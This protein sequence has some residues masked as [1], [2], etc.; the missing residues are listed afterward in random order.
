MTVAQVWADD[1]TGA[2]EAAHTWQNASGGD[3]RIL[4]GIPERPTPESRT[5]CDLDLRHSTDAEV[6][7]RLEPAAD[8]LD[9]HTSLFFKVDSQLRGPVRTYLEVLLDTGRPVV[10]SAANPALGRIT[11]DGRHHVPDAAGGG[12]PAELRSVF[13]GLPHHH[14]GAAEYDQIPS[15]LTGDTPTLVTA[16]VSSGADL[17]RLARSCR[18]GPRLHAA[19][20][21]PFLD[22]LARSEVSGRGPAAGTGVPSRPVQ[23]L[24]AVLGT[25]EPTGHA[26]VQALRER[27]PRTALVT[28]PA[29]EDTRAI[30]ESARHVRAALARGVH[31][32]LTPPPDHT[33]A[34]HRTA[35]AMAALAATCRAALPGAGADVCLYLSGGYTARRV[36]DRLGFTELR[37]IPGTHDVVAHLVAPDGRTVLTKPGSYGDRNTLI[38]LTRPAPSCDTPTP[39]KET[40]GGLT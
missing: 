7:A 26:Q 1:L 22:A 15:L 34:G 17:A 6:R 14:L 3:I 23:Q 16:D 32:V 18:S 37:L 39:D 33:A 29:T 30:A 31:A 8:Q 28:A 2:A 11:A 19:G 9:G 36:L 25:T 24:F 35:E 10:L 4:L 20:S 5:V 40:S 27:D 38:D 21:A 13:A 12:P